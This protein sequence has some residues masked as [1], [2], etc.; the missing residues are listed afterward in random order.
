MVSIDVVLMSIVIIQNSFCPL[1]NPHET[2]LGTRRSFRSALCI[3]NKVGLSLEMANVMKVV[4]DAL[5]D[6]VSL[7]NVRNVKN[8]HG[9]VLLLEAYNFTKNN[10]LPWVFF[11]YF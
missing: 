7:Y 2:E 1:K 9:G 6:L 10:T 4:C 11:T 8:T 5:R 3:N